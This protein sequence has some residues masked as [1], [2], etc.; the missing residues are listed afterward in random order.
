M[1]S[2]VRGQRGVQGQ[3]SGQLRRAAA[4]RV[5]VDPV[6]VEPANEQRVLAAQVHHLAGRHRHAASLG[7]AQGGVLGGRYIEGVTSAGKFGQPQQ[8]IAVAHRSL[9]PCAARAGAGAE[10]VGQPCRHR[11]AQ[12]DALCRFKQVLQGLHLGHAGGRPVRQVAPHV[13]GAHTLAP[14]LQ[15]VGRLRQAVRRHLEL[16][17]DDASA[18]GIRGGVAQPAKQRQ[19]VDRHQRLLAHLGLV[20]QREADRVDLD[21]L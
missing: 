1:A 4:Q 10:E 6:P 11:L 15:Q 20:G 21:G 16:R 12:L 9:G 8:A 2:R 3:V 18:P 17:F 13:Q 14:G 19:A 5:V 7:Q